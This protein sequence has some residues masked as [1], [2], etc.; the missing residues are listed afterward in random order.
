MKFI[1]P[2]VSEGLFILIKSLKK[3]E[4][5]NFKLFVNKQTKI[6]E[7]GTYTRLFDLI[8]KQQIYNEQVL[9][10]K[11]NFDQRKLTS[12]KYLLYELI[13]KSLRHLNSD[14]NPDFKL[15]AFLDKV[16][17]LFNKAL[18]RQSY[19]MLMK[20]KKIA[21]SYDKYTYLPEI[22]RWNKKL[23]AY[24]QEGMEMSN[25]TDFLEE[26]RKINSQVQE[27]LKL[28]ELSDHLNFIY[29]A[30]MKAR[31][32]QDYTKLELIMSSSVL[33]NPQQNFRGKLA[34]YEVH[35]IYYD[36]VNLPLNA[37]L[38]YR[39]IVA[40]WEKDAGKIANFSELYRKHLFSFL[41]LGLMTNQKLNYEYWLMKLHRTPVKSPQEEAQSILI[42]AVIEILCCIHNKLPANAPCTS[43]FIHLAQEQTIHCTDPF[44]QFL[45]EYYTGL[46]YFL[47]GDPG[48]ALQHMNQLLDAEYK[49][50]GLG[51]HHFIR[52]LILILHLE[53]GNTDFIDYLYRSTYRFLKN[54]SDNIDFELMTIK[55]VR[56]V[57]NLPNTPDQ[58]KIW[59]V[60]E[61][62]LVNVSKQKIPMRNFEYNILLAW[63]KSKQSK[64][65][66]GETYQMVYQN[67]TQRLIVK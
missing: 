4:K 63:V 1:S 42:G 31:T 13:L 41:K 30:I 36:L 54:S 23:F 15:R 34:Y 52:M 65:G 28:L 49:S 61:K 55:Y 6:A 3:A 14:Q 48:Q 7:V 59:Q 58:G 38:E 39:K 35:G 10:K 43:Q 26:N 57:S 64:Q 16:E 19:K 62:K 50:V 56:K 22:Q 5:R 44:W 21:F 66:I 32:V 18:Y 60:L 46:Y 25:V 27:E 12:T 47:S 53:L 37:H 11:M 40:L 51:I 20:A 2:P 9:I 8:D 24:T 29:R 33:H 17:I 45:L 67:D